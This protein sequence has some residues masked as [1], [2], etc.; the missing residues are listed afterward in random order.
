ME[1]AVRVET[2][3]VLAVLTLVLIRHSMI[4]QIF[5]TRETRLTAEMV[6]ED[7]AAAHHLMVIRV[8]WVNP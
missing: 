5:L 8:L 6:A 4:S 2:A 3:E 7:I 1:T